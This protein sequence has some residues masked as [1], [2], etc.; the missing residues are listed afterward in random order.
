MPRGTRL[1]NEDEGSSEEENIDE[2]ELGAGRRVDRPPSRREGSRSSPAGGPGHIS[3]G[4]D[5]EEISAKRENWERKYSMLELGLKILRTKL[6]EDIR[7]DNLQLVVV[8]QKACK[9]L[10]RNFN[11]LN[12]ESFFNKD[13]ATAWSD[14][15]EKLPETIKE[16]LI[17]KDNHQ[18][19]DQERSKT[20][21][22]G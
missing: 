13:S 10:L 7:T 20:E 5:D 16:R 3:E 19:L 11:A 17:R 9:E 15:I 1:F 21:K 12:V 4:D 8:R 14:T 6:R 2:R 22:K 18:F